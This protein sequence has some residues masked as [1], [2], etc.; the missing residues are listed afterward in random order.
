MRIAIEIFYQSIINDKNMWSKY[1][2][3]AV[4]WQKKC[5]FYCIMHLMRESLELR[6]GSYQ[7]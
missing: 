2:H 6:L 4:T 7:H 1:F 5:P 3:D